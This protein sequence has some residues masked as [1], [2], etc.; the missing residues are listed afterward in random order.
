MMVEQLSRA[1]HRIQA[2]Q[3]RASGSAFAARRLAFASVA[4]FV[5]WLLP[6]TLWAKADESSFAEAVAQGPVAAGFATLLAGLAVSLTPCVYPMIAVTVSVFGAQQAR[7]RA[8]AALLSATFVLGIIVM[9]TP[10]GVVA[11]LTGEA[12]GSILSNVWVVSGI[13]LLFFAMAASMF[14]AFD[15]DLPEGMKN[16]LATVG[17]GGFAGA[18]VLGL[19]CGPIAA[20]CT[21]PFLTGILA[22]IAKLQDPMVGGLVMA[23]FALGLGIPF[24]LVGAFAMHLPKSG[25]WMVHVKS[26]LGIVLCVVALYFLSTAFPLLGKWASASPVF[27]GGTLFVALVGLFFGAVHRSYEGST[28]GV[29]I[30]KSIGLLLTVSGTFLFIMGFI[31]PE[32]TLTW[33]GASTGELGAAMLLEPAL[34]RAQTSGQPVLVDFTASWCAACKELDKLTFADEKVAAEAGRFVAVKVDATDQDDPVVAHV[35]KTNG[36]LGLPTVIL[37]GSDG[38]EH[39]RFNN[40][41]PPEEFLR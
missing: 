28:I 32:R 38:R 23:T 31:A 19:V 39:K 4:L 37:F 26:L 9:F 27:L 34:D 30:S 7:S 21:G 22:W 10:L 18:F 24:F 16:R 1:S 2:F 8:Q 41:V 33:E 20:P 11:A 35:L 25:R 29:A 14:G 13:S 3:S 40:F 36:V 5:A 17:G 6:A 15:L 12:F